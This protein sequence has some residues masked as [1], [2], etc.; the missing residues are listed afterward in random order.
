MR[1]GVGSGK[2]GDEKYLREKY[3]NDEHYVVNSIERIY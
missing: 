2:V 1:V 3:A